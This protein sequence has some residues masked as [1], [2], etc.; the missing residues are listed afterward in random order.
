MG[1]LLCTNRFALFDVIRLINVLIIRY[2]L[3][4]KIQ[5]NKKQKLGYIIY[6]RANSMEKLRT[7]GKT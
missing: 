6:I 1:L 4:C 7:I 5:R 3:E 2:D